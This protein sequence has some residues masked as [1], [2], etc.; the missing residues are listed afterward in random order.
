MISWKEEVK[1][2]SKG[3]ASNSIMA[4]E[5]V[6]AMAQW[7]KNPTAADR[8]TA[9]VWVRSLAQGSGLKDLA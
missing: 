5:G 9:E 2:E 6:P 8:V 7:V 3:A 1:N 4:N